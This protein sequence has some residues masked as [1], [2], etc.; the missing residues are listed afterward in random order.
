MLQ[1]DKR[2]RSPKERIQ[3]FGEIA[4]DLTPEEA[5]A[6]AQWC[7]RSGCTTPLCET[8]CPLRNPIRRPMHLIAQGQ[9]VQAALIMHRFNNTVEI[10]SRVC[11]QDLLCAGKC[12]LGLIGEPIAI[13][14]L[15]RFVTDYAFQ[16]GA[17]LPLALPKST[18]KRVA[19]VGSGPTGLSCAEELVKKGHGVNVFDAMPRP[20]GLL[21][22]AIPG[23]KMSPGVVE[24]RLGY[25]RS[26][27]IEFICNT[28]V[29]KDLGLDDLLRGGY[30]AV[31]LA[32]GA[33]QPKTPPIEGMDLENVVDA[34]SFV[35]RNVAS[36]ADL[37]P[38]TGRR[39]DLKH[40]RVV[41]LGGGDTA[42]GCS[43]AAVRMGSVRT[44]CLYRRDEA[45]MPGSRHM[46]RWAKEEGVE[47]E[48]LSA[49]VR[50]LADQ[51]RKMKG[52]ECIRM[53]LSEPGAD[54]RRRSIPVEGS[55]FVVEADFAVLAFGFDPNRLPTSDDRLKVNGDGTYAVDDNHTTSLRSVFAGGSVTY[56]MGLVVTAVKDGCDTADTIDR[57][58]TL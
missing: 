5:I 45:S 48:F 31:C 37:P 3:D 8:G 9:F 53:T 35:L 11:P 30:D 13:G 49:P 7:V 36:P 16:Q 52:V 40:K 50:F 22:Y 39:D 2:E 24:R 51:D 47:F 54:A 56:G 44:T 15:E 1:L 10:C 57:F 38:G 28:C 46:V 18:G 58:L 41:V 21:T 26:I 42:M 43:R 20:G 27:G 55:N 34:A 6:E 25:L 4:L 32:T 19:I 29:G 23:F 14:P 33:M 17:R 12:V